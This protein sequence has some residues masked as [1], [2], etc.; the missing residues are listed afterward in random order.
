M[1]NWFVHWKSTRIIVLSLGLCHWLCTSWLH[2]SSYFYAV[3]SWFQIRELTA[4]LISR[5]KDISRKTYDWLIRQ[6]YWCRHWCWSRPIVYISTN[7]IWRLLVFEVDFNISLSSFSLPI[8]I[9]NG[10][11]EEYCVVRVLFCTQHKGI[12]KKLDKLTPICFHL[13][14]LKGYVSV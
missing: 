1:S 12:A 6:M 2:F 14:K 4:N 10:F 7:V 5:A 13:E 8:T 9:G 3:G 11:V